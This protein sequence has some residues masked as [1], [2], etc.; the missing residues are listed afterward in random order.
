MIPVLLKALLCVFALW[1]VAIIITVVVAL[2]KTQW[3]RTEIKKAVK[4]H[5]SET[6][7]KYGAFFIRRREPITDFTL[8]EEIT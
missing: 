6:G 2:A 8:W 5:H 4:K 3:V 7:T 1:I